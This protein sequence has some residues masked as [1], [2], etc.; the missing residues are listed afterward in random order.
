MTTLRQF[1]KLCSRAEKKFARLRS[2][3]CKGYTQADL[4]AVREEVFQKVIAK[5]IA[6]D[7][8]KRKVKR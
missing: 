2:E 8:K 6:A 1:L 5:E 7:R 3:E 4:I